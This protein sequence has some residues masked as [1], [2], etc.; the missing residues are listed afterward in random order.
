MQRIRPWQKIG[1][2]VYLISLF[3]HSWRC[4]DVAILILGRVE[5]WHRSRLKILCCKSPF[6]RFSFHNELMNSPAVELEENFD[7]EGELLASEYCG[8]NAM[9]NR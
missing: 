8:L 3:R 5:K 2:N 9:K 1:G 4:S 6:T 7:Q